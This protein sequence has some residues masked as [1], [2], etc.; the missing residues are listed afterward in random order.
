MDHYGS[1][2]IPRVIRSLRGN[3]LFPLSQTVIPTEVRI[4][5]EWESVV[6]VSLAFNFPQANFYIELESRLESD[7]KEHFNWFRINTWLR[8]LVQS[9]A[10]KQIHCEFIMTLRGS[11]LSCE[12]SHQRMDA[13]NWDVWQSVSQPPSER[14]I[15]VKFPISTDLG[16]A[17]PTPIPTLPIV[18]KML[19]LPNI[20]L[21][22]T[23]P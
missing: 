23:S 18:G 9:S 22:A 3:H 7:K 16:L 20:S 12:E 15:G 14:G 13:R 11:Q 4:S 19:H 6:V 10:W 5:L 1:G 21:G 8:L 17:F 2:S